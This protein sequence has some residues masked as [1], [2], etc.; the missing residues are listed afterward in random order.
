MDFIRE[1]WNNRVS[2]EDFQL[3]VQQQQKDFILSVV[4]G[5]VD[6]CGNQYEPNPLFM[7]YLVQLFNSN[8]QLSMSVFFDPSKVNLF[9]LI[10]LIIHCGDVLFNNLEI[11][12][13]FSARCAMNALKIC[14]E[15]QNKELSYEAVTKLSESPT[16]SV[17]I[18]SARLF[19]RDE[20]I[21][22]RELFT[23]IIPQSDL[24]PS[25]PFPITLLRRAMLEDNLTSSI[26]FTVHDIATAVITN[27]DL[28][29]F[30]PCSKSFI[31]PS[32]FYHLYLHVVSGFIANPTLQLA[33]MTTNLL[34]RIL[35]HMNDDSEISTEE[36][37][38]ETSRYWRILVSSLFSDLRSNLISQKNSGKFELKHRERENCDFLGQLDDL[39]QIEKLL[40]DLPSQVDEDQI[41]NIVYQYPASSSTLVEHMLK[42]MN[43]KRPEIAVS[44]ANQILPI[45]SDFEWLLLR[46]GNFI[47]FISQA[48]NLASSIPNSFDPKAF[49]K[50]WL[51]PLTLIRFMWGTSSNSV[52]AQIIKFVESQPSGI[53]QFLKHLIQYHHDKDPILLNDYTTPFNECI[54]ILKDLL[55]GEK[56]V[57]SI[58]L[59]EKSYLWVSVLLWAN[60]KVPDNYEVL[61]ETPHPN[62]HLV[63]FLFS[64]SMLAIVK[65][66]R[67]WMSAA[68]EPDLVNMLVFRPESIFDINTLIVDQLGLFCRVTPMTAEQLTKIVAAW[69][70]W[71][72]IFG[73]K[74]FTKTLLSQLVWK[75]M[76]SLIPEDAD[77][78][79]KSIAYVLAVLISENSDDVNKVLEV[80]A[81]FVEYEIETM[82]SAIG[83]A[84]FTFIIVCTK[85][86]KW[87]E[88]FDW[89]L[90]YCFKILDD[91]PAL[92]NTKTSFA[93]SVL[94]T[95]LYTQRLQEKVTEE[96]FDILYK[97]KD[98][99][100]MIDFFIVKQSVQDESKSNSH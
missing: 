91:D 81:S 94:K 70:A 76:H 12:T 87:E 60:E 75:T 43:M 40:T 11:G 51:L 80:I 3:E 63:N 14:L 57:T 18:S 27:I 45:H 79:Y 62:E 53:R 38:E 28:W 29:H 6:L 36:K 17:L 97:I 5:L 54:T 41:I 30:I 65:P 64:T 20:I 86:H 19:F 68:E 37:E 21:S 33:Y 31:T 85:K 25:I 67:R 84:D 13:D 2:P 66:V 8:L 69:R 47:E 58:D 83:L 77:N 16:F 24:P 88:S 72:E 46:Q 32:S 71:V 42:N 74:D 9:G 82:T 26:L 44:Y 10:R 4:I 89:L 35:R 96:A 93:L 55:N 1:S 98:W 73:I 52:R 22:L 50:L 61:T 59:N 56:L 100:T 99:Q 78:L 49:E 92:Q 15:H 34:V 23:Q 90:K 95:S 48:L 39:V 7:Q